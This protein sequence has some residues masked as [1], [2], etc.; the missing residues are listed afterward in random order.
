M[1]TESVVRRELRRFVLENGAAEEVTD[2][3]LLFG[4]GVLKSVQVMDLILLIEELSGRSLSIEDLHPGS[5]QTIDAIYAHFFA[6]R[7][8]LA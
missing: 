6:G 5:F 7:E 8:V 3:A 1:K 4:S 2:Q